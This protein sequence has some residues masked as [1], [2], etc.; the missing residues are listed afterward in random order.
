[1]VDF[2]DELRE[3]TQWGFNIQPVLYARKYSPSSS[4]ARRGSWAA[5]RCPGV[6]GEGAVSEAPTG[7]GRLDYSL[8]R[9]SHLRMDY[10]LAQE[11]SP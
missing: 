7:F 6:H 5:L 9:R 11:M 4:W 8:P 3:R 10:L 2:C 1:M